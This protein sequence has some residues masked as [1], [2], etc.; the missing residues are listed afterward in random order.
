MQESFSLRF[1]FLIY[2]F[3]M[4]MANI[5]RVVY[6]SYTVNRQTP[7]FRDRAAV[8]RFV[9]SLL[10]FSV[11]VFFSIFFRLSSLFVCFSFVQEML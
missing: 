7:V 3:Q 4:L 8:I 10:P 5:G 11:V 6:P 2:R 1:P 9:Y